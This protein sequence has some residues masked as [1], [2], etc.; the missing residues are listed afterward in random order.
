MEDEVVEVE[1]VK[2]KERRISK[3]AKGKLLLNDKGGVRKTFL[4]L[5][6]FKIE[7]NVSYRKGR[8]WNTQV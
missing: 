3:P 2:E 5:I 7:I 4:I 8:K 1:N 6:K